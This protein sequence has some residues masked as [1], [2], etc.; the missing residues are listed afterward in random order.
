MPQRH[1]LVPSG[2]WRHRLRRAHVPELV[3]GQRL[4]PRW[5]VPLLPRVWRSRV[6][7]ARGTDRAAARALR[8]RLRTRLPRALPLGGGGELLPGVHLGVLAKVRH[9]R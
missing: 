3:L 7:G 4:V 2:L 9:E 5:R 1:V 8:A 6:R